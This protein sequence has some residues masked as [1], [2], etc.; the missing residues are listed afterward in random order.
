MI[1]LITQSIPYDHYHEPWQAQYGDGSG[2]EMYSIPVYQ[3]LFGQKFTQVSWF[4]YHHY[5]I[6][7][8]AIRIYVE[9]TQSNHIALNPGANYVLKSGDELL[10]IA[11]DT[12]FVSSLKQLVIISLIF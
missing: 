3:T 12:G 9:E 5:Q 11:Q 2:N 1:N 7:L 10:F 6:I 8:F 4:L